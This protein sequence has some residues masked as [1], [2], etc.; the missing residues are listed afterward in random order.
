MSAAMRLISKE[1]D[2]DGFCDTGC[3]TFLSYGFRTP[4]FIQPIHTESPDHW[5]VASSL[6]PCTPGTILVYDSLL[7]NSERETLPEQIAALL[8]WQDSQFFVHS[9]PCPTQSGARDCGIFAIAVMTELILG[10]SLKILNNFYPSGGWKWDQRKMRTHLITCFEN[11]KI[12]VFP[13]VEIPSLTWDTTAVSYRIYEPFCTCRQVN[14]KK[15]M[16]IVKNLAKIS[17]SNSNCRLVYH[18]SCL[19]LTLPDKNS[20]LCLKCIN[21]STS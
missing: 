21:P 18:E 19:G 10:N 1:T 11:R 7:S 20:W 13:K 15:P 14:S 9:A 16:D 17:S 8:H 12:A 2:V 4:H 6:D 3:S 5:V